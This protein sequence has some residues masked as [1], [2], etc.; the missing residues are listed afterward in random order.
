MLQH[1]EAKR[2]RAENREAQEHKAR[3]ELIEKEESL[4]EDLETE[5]EHAQ[6]YEKRLQEC[7]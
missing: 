3:Q 5:K 7:T 2:L 1:N 4:I 6:Q